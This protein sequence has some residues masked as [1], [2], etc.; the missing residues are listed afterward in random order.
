[1]SGIVEKED[2]RALRLT[3]RAPNSRLPLGFTCTG[4]IG[5]DSHTQVQHDVIQ[6]NIFRY[7]CVYVCMYIYIYIY[8]HVTVTMLYYISIGRRGIRP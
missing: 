2:R 5:A 1:M 4:K 8:I 6:I 7:V 3:R